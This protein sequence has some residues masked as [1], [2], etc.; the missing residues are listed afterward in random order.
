[1]LHRSLC[2]PISN[3]RYRTLESTLLHYFS[4][5]MISF[6]S[7]LLLFFPPGRAR[8][9]RIVGIGPTIGDRPLTLRTWIICTCVL[10]K[11]NFSKHFWNRSWSRYDY[12]WRW[13]RKE[14]IP[15]T[16]VRRSGYNVVFPTPII[17]NMRTCVRSHTCAHTHLYLMLFIFFISECEWC[18]TASKGQTKHIHK[19]TRALW[20]R[21]LNVF[22]CYL[23]VHFEC[24]PLRTP[25]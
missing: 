12:R 20:A 10:V 22:F 7:F 2:L 14:K 9:M 8:W 18:H 3:N 17:Y 11:I 1:M 15:Y 13:G 23:D 5:S 19:H 4:P 6:I 25:L 24:F 21:V 16:F